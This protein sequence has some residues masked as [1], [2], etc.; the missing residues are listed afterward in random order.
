[1]KVKEYKNKYAKKVISKNKYVDKKAVD[2]NWLITVTVLAF[3]ISVVFSGISEALI[4]NINI[5]FSILLVLFVIAIGVVF[6]MVG[7][8][9]TSADIKTFNSMAAKNVRGAKLGINFIKKADKVSSF[10]NDVIG[11]ICSIIS[12]SGGAAISVILAA[13]YKLN[14]FFITL[15]V[16]ATIAAITIGGKAAGKSLAVNKSDVILYEFSKVLSFFYKKENSK[17]Y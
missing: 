1:M 11:D 10:C 9:T 8:A 3:L 2:W 17:L 13:E 7:I 14:V 15:L 5:I 6:D 16:T 4:P 12:G